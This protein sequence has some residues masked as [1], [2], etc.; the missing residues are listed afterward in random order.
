MCQK[1]LDIMPACVSVCV[2][3]VCVCVGCH[4]ALYAFYSLAA[5]VFACRA[6]RRGTAR[7]FELI[8]RVQQQPTA[9]VLQYAMAHTQS[10]D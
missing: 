3:G 7:Y 10:G 9:A 1:T 5:V 4:I 8:S 2:A 6:Q